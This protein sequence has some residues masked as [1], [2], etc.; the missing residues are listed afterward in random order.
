MIITFPPLKLWIALLLDVG[1]LVQLDGGAIMQVAGLHVNLG[2]NR[3]ATQT[4][5]CADTGRVFHS[6]VAALA[7]T[8]MFLND[9]LAAVVGKSARRCTAGEQKA[10]CDECNA[11]CFGNALHGFTFS[12]EAG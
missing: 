12:R 5:A 3:L 2:A 7:G 10:T 8:V 1:S 4:N 6:C 9:C 11:C